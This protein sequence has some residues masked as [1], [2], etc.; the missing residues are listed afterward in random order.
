MLIELIISDAPSNNGLSDLSRRYEVCFRNPSSVRFE[1]DTQ[2]Y[3]GANLS[4]LHAAAFYLQEVFE[5]QGSP[6]DCPALY[7]FTS[8]DR[9]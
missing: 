6:R 8:E 3:N 5:K 2:Q 9:S 7:L 4:F 1:T